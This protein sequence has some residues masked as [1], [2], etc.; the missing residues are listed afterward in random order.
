[1]LNTVPMGVSLSGVIGPR[2]WITREAHLDLL[3]SGAV[4]YSGSI[5]THGSTWPSTASYFYGT[6]GGGNTGPKTS[7][8]NGM[9][10]SEL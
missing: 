3:S 5:V 9:K 1:M 7:E 6:V 2:P 4:T 10:L 8:T